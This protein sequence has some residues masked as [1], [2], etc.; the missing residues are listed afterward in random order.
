MDCHDMEK[1][2]MEPTDFYKAKVNCSPD[3]GETCTLYYECKHSPKVMLMYKRS[4]GDEPV[5]IVISRGM[6]KGFD[7]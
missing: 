7:F 3:T 4:Y 5:E 1:N 6:L 2:T